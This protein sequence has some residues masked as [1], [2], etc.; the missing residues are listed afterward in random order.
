[1]RE[2]LPVASLSY[3]EILPFEAAANDMNVDKILNNF[4]K[5]EEVECIK[6]IALN[7]V[8]NPMAMQHI[9]TWHENTYLHNDK[10]I[11][12]SSQWISRLLSKI[13]Q[14]SLPSFPDR[15]VKN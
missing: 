12:F 6:A 5:P 8:T 1:V 14:S 7:R 13:G 2:K 10:S 4:L 9:E 11:S 3:G 15:V